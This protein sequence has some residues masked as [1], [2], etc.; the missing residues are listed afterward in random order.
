M[1]AAYEHDF[2]IVATPLEN[3]AAK[4]LQSPNGKFACNF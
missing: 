3:Q 2:H 1:D 4:P